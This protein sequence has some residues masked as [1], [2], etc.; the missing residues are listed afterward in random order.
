MTSPCVAEIRYSCKVSAPKSDNCLYFQSNSAFPHLCKFEVEGSDECFN[1]LPQ[2]VALPNQNLKYY[3]FSAPYLPYME[4]KIRRVDGVYPKN[5]NKY[6]NRK[7]STCNAS[8]IR[9][10]KEYFSKRFR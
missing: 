6:W 2:K 1:H 8:S 7:I 3:Y 4:R 10:S 5:F 9:R